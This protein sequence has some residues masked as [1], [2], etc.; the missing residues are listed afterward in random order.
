MRATMRRGTAEAMQTQA[1]CQAAHTLTKAQGLSKV[2]FAAPTCHWC[3]H[4]THECI[5]RSG[6][7]CGQR[8]Q[9]QHRQIPAGMH[10]MR[11]RAQVVTT[12]PWHQHIHQSASLHVYALLLS[13]AL[14]GL[15]AAGRWQ[16]ALCVAERACLVVMC[17][18]CVGRGAS[19]TS[20]R[21]VS[22]Q[23]LHMRALARAGNGQARWRRDECARAAARWTYSGARICASILAPSPLRAY[24][25]V[26]GCVLLL[27]YSTGFALALAW[28]NALDRT[29][30]RQR[31]HLIHAH[32]LADH[33]MAGVARGTAAPYTHTPQEGE[34]PPSTATRTAR[35]LAHDT[36]THTHTHTLTPTHPPTHTHTHTHR[37]SQLLTGQHRSA[38]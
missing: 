22:A 26:L 35:A 8:D 33:V 9:V 3:A 7:C 34:C 16:C 28:A 14:R 30:L 36:H 1:H 20:R 37:V 5:H 31:S 10:T 27:Y 38:C 24:G 11:S 15:G 12:S 2:A 6:W 23:P 29:F 4:Q 25:E 21:T 19:A 32:S 13:W 18:S 17:A